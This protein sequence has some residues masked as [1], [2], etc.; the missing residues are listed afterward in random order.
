[1]ES[2]FTQYVLYFFLISAHDFAKTVYQNSCSFSSA[3]MPYKPHK[4][5]VNVIYSNALFHMYAVLLQSVICIR[6]LRS[7][8]SCTNLI[9]NINYLLRFSYTLQHSVTFCTNH[10]K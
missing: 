4:I 3:E 1:M 5:R 6:L 9:S 8:Q 2:F 10:E 7:E